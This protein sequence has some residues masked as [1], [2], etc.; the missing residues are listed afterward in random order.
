PPF[1]FAIC[2]S[3]SVSITLSIPQRAEISMT[4]PH[5]AIPEFEPLSCL[6][7]CPRTGAVW[8]ECDILFSLV[9]PRITIF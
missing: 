3:L 2:A 6:I 7:P 1:F 4:F 8:Q 9:L 5:F